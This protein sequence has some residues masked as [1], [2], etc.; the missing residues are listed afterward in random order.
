MALSGRALVADDSRAK[1]FSHN[2]MGWE[3]EVKFAKHK[4]KTAN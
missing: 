2:P 3:K 1:G 4:K